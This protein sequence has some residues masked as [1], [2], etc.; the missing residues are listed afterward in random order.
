MVIYSMKAKFEESIM[1]VQSWFVL[2]KFKYYSTFLDTLIQT[3]WNITRTSLKA[4]VDW[5]I[6]AFI[7]YIL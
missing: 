3:V 6:L 2:R 1:L 4:L 7:I 5:I